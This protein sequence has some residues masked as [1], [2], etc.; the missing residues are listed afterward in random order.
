MAQCLCRL[1]V[2]EKCLLHLRDYGFLHSLLVWIRIRS[3]FPSQHVQ[4][5]A[6]EL[7]LELLLLYKMQRRKKKKKEKEKNGYWQLFTV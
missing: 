6:R 1:L 4:H 2:R 3:D 5:P 7:F